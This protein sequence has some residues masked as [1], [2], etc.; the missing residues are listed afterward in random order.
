V[1]TSF[2]YTWIAQK[3]K[4]TSN[5]KY[6]LYVAG[7]FPKER[8]LEIMFFIAIKAFENYVNQPMDHST[9]VALT[10]TTCLTTASSESTP[11]AD[12]GNVKKSKQPAS[13]T[14]SHDL[15]KLQPIKESNYER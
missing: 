5:N 6:S 1:V 13:N 12:S 10:S 4:D 14:R 8:F 3:V 15:M 7:P 9:S 2:D 11:S